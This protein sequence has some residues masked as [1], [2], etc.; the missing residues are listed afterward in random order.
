MLFNARLTESPCLTPTTGT[1]QAKPNALAVT[2][3]LR[4]AE[5]L[6]FGPQLTII[7]KID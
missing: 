5:N 2:T 4:I 7:P 1:S 6:P 3:P